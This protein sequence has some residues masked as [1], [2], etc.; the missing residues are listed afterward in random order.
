MHNLY[1]LL[2]CGKFIYRS[3]INRALMVLIDVTTK[4]RNKLTST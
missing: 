3:E 4:E 2:I 1:E